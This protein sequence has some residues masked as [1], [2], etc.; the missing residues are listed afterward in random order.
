MLWLFLPTS[1]EKSLVC[2]LYLVPI[3]TASIVGILTIKKALPMIPHFSE[4][5]MVSGLGGLVAGFIL[6]VA[7][8]AADTIANYSQG[9]PCC[10]PCS[11]ILASHSSTP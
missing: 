2:L 7:N 1:I 9:K 10:Y 6:G 3:L 8:L 4:A 5:V 11:L